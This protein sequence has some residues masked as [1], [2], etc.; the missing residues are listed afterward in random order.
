MSY[1]RQNTFF[2]LLGEM[3]EGEINCTFG[4]TAEKRRDIKA[5]SEAV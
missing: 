3:C 4:Q 2:L 1:W 5:V